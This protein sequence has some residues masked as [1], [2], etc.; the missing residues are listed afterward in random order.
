[1][2]ARYPVEKAYG[3]EGPR[4]DDLLG[5][6][7]RPKRRRELREER[8]RERRRGGRGSRSAL[9]GLIELVLTVA[10]AFALVFFVVR[11]FIVMSYFTPTESMVPTIAAE[12]DRVLVNKFVYRFEEPERGDV[13]VL[14]DPDGGDQPLLKR[15][16]GLPGEEI[17]VQNGL[18]FVNDTVVREGYL[19]VDAV[20]DPSSYGPTTV[21]EGHVFVMG[22]NRGSSQDSR[23]YGPVPQENLEGEAF[24]RFWPPNRLAWL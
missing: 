21:P 14:E 22:D 23:V 5:G 11:P 3:E 19:N 8:E 7:E 24:V 10:I 18:L 15:V 16:V 1:L 17:R 9:G 6:G 2:G 12:T 13:V 4:D 20:P